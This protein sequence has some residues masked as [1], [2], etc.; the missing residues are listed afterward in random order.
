[1]SMLGRKW[2]VVDSVGGDFATSI[3]AQRG[4]KTQK[5]KDKFS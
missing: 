1:M 2:E 3:L 5:D 4:V